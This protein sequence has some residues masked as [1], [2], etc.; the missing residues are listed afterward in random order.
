MGNTKKLA[1][2]HADLVS[3]IKPFQDAFTK[4]GEDLTTGIDTAQSDLNHAIKDLKT[5]LTAIRGAFFYEKSPE[6]L[7][8]PTQQQEHEDQDK[9]TLDT[10]EGPQP[11]FGE[12]LRYHEK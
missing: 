5:E 6:D 9:Q 10:K 7:A 11:V 4:A 3:N 12:L 8:R 1:D 2:A